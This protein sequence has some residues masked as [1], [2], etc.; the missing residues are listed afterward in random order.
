MCSQYTIVSALVQHASPTIC[1]YIAMAELDQAALPNNYPGPSH[2]HIR[3]HHFAPWLLSRAPSKATSHLCP[4][5]PSTT[6][7]TTKASPSTTPALHCHSTN[8]PPPTTLKHPSTKPNRYKHPHA[9]LAS[10]KHARPSPNTAGTS[11]S[12]C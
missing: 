2:P 7:S 4:L 10:P 1:F 12:S 11:R 3:K 9:P 8:K 5:P 6:T